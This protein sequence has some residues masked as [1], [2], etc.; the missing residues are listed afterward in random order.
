MRVRRVCGRS[1][2]LLP[3]LIVLGL[4]GLL[5]GGH[6]GLSNMARFDLPEFNRLYDASRSLP[7]SPA[8]TKM[9]ALFFLT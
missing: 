2:Y 7:D 6:A 4:L 8:R 5:Y 1:N 9:F 3:A